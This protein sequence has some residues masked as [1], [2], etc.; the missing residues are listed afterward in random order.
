MEKCH[1]KA[2]Y[3]LTPIP[4]TTYPLR[5][6]PTVPVKINMKK[7]RKVPMVS[8]TSVPDPQVFFWPLPDPS[9]TRYSPDPITTY[10]FVTIF[11]NF[12]FDE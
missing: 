8:L 9:V 5:C 1:V 2:K 7:H 12:I 11:I 10:H 6:T 3:S 4:S